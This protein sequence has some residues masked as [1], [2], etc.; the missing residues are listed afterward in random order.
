MFEKGNHIRLFK[1]ENLIKGYKNKRKITQYIAKKKAKNSSERIKRIEHRGDY[2]RISRTGGVAERASFS[3]K[4][5]GIGA[6]VNTMH[7]LRILVSKSVDT[8]CV[9]KLHKA[10]N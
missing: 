7:G 4:K 10:C 8:M 1:K 9:D 5:M 2:V 3:N 6:T